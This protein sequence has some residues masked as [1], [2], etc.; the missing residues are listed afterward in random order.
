M[1]KLKIGVWEGFWPIWRHLESFWKIQLYMDSRT[2]P[3]QNQKLHWTWTVCLTKQSD[4]VIVCLW[5][6]TVYCQ[7]DSSWFN[8]SHF[9]NR[10]ELWGDCLHSFDEMSI[11]VVSF[12]NVMHSRWRWMISDN[13]NV[14]SRAGLRSYH[15][16]L[17]ELDSKISKDSHRTWIS[18]INNFALSS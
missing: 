16:L 13:R 15:N 1:W 8:I 14:V 4:L 10:S 12:F 18:L 17:L 2:F 9:L 6:A 11:S 3:T 7:H 5:V